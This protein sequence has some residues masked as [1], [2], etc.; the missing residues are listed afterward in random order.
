M[1]KAEKRMR[2][3]TVVASNRKKRHEE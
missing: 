1:Q 3:M 2:E